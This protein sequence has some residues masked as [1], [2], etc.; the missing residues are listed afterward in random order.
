MKFHWNLSDI[1]VNRIECA[2][3]CVHV[4]VWYVVWCFVCVCVRVS[5]SLSV[6]VYVCVRVCVC[7][8]ERE[9]VCVFEWECV[10]VCVRVSVH[11]LPCAPESHGCTTITTTEAFRY[12][13]GLFC[14][15][16]CVAARG[17]QS[18]NRRDCSQ[19]TVAGE[20]WTGIQVRVCKWVRMCIG[21][22]SIDVDLKHGWVMIGTCCKKKSNT[23]HLC[24]VNGNGPCTSFGT[25]LCWSVSDCAF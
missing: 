12:W 1:S 15:L 14:C 2:C 7:E 10:S 21:W 18:R 3:V 25:K 11:D 23:I 5:L 13:S 20:V 8:R 22:L 4:D 16:L 6:C 24:I 19:R 9:R 17:Y